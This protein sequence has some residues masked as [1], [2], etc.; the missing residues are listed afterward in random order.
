M[1]LNITNSF[2]LVEKLTPSIYLVLSKLEK[3]KNENNY[4][5][6]D[7]LKISSYFSSCTTEGFFFLEK[8]CLILIFFY[9]LTNVNIF[10]KIKLS[11]KEAIEKI[12]LILF[13][14]PK[15]LFLIK[16]YILLMKLEE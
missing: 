16:F 4:N 7:T 3:F 14:I 11:I 8:V 12:I 1:S 9:D 13:L 6:D 2:D 10:Q 15:I 5:P